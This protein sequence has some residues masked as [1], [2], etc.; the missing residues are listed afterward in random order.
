MSGPAAVEVRPL[1][2]ADAARVA[3]LHLLAFPDYESTRLGPRYC[4]RLVLAYAARPD[5]W[6]LV[7]AA[8]GQDAAGF[9]VGAPPAAQREVNRSLLV[10]WGV[11]GALRSPRRLLGR[12]SGA[13]SRLRRRRGPVE[14]GSGP[15]PVPSGTDAARPRATIRLVLVGVDPAARGQG[16][17]DALLEAFAE[18]ARSAGHDTA[19]LS[20]VVANSAARGLYARH[21]WQEV[22]VEGAEVA[23]R[24]RLDLTGSGPA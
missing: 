3:E 6:V 15:D 5:S 10:P 11:L 1:R 19:D 23:V 20:V 14:V 13:R 21:G 8:P 2:R 16:V 18:R 22:A 17:A 4:R 7:A 9:L 24:C 12:V